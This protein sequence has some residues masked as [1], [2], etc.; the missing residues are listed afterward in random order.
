MNRQGEASLLLSLGHLFV[1]DGNSDEAIECYE[2][3]AQCG[4]VEAMEI[5]GMIYFTDDPEYAAGIYEKAAKLGSTEAMYNLSLMYFW[6]LGKEKSYGQSL[7]Y[8]QMAK[9]NERI[10]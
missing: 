6:G 5:L 7:K 10:L 4:S 9:Q 1:K 3:A 2:E 8:F